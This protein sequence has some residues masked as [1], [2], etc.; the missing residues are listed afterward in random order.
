MHARHR[1]PGYV[2]DQKN[3]SAEGL[4]FQV[5]ADFTRRAA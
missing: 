3:E 4:P 5:F 2:G 1:D